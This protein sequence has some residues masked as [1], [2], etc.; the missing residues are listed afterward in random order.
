MSSRVTPENRGIGCSGVKGT[1]GLL[2]SLFQY[3]WIV[4]GNGRDVFLRYLLLRNVLRC[5][6][7]TEII[8]IFLFLEILEFKNQ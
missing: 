1:I 7:S 2:L 5:P 3:H 4:R 8:E 6:L